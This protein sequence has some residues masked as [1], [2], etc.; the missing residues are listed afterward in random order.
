[1]RP[2]FSLST[3]A[4]TAFC[5]ANI[6]FPLGS[7]SIIFCVM[8]IG[9]AVVLFR[10]SKTPF[11]KN[12][13]KVLIGINTILIV[14]FL[15]KPVLFKDEVLVDKEVTE[16]QKELQLEAQDELNT[17]EAEGILDDVNA[18]EETTTEATEQSVAETP[19]FETEEVEFE[20]PS[21]Q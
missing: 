5:I 11:K 19:Q 16:Q 6:W 13:P 17:L 15:L 10:L 4:L 9:F 14:V 18:A 8:A 1:M 2:L 21:F 7:I 3:I 20:Q 12:L